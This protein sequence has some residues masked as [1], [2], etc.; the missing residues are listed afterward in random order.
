MTAT[1]QS[2]TLNVFNS[3]RE[4][5]V[6]IQNP[7]S[8][9]VDLG[10]AIVLSVEGDQLLMLP[11]ATIAA[12]ASIRIVSGTTAA[13]VGDIQWTRSNVW[14]NEGDTAA[15][16]TAA[17]SLMTT[18]TYGRARAKAPAIISTIKGSRPRR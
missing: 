11:D 17:G 16:Y 2:P 7:T 6:E 5:Y 10:N 4:E 8:A 1:A 13:R 15:L 12:G 14:N 9:A 18:T 3:G